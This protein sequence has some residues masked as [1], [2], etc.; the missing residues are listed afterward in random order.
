MA[1]INI[2]YSCGCGFVTHK[3]EAAV[4]HAD[5]QKHTLTVLGIVQKSE[6]PKPEERI[7]LEGIPGLRQRL[8]RYR[9]SRG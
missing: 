7:S 3:L 6:L 5:T 1:S 9:G 2:T 4:E 8:E